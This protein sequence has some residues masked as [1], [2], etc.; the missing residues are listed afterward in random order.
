MHMLKSMLI[1]IYPIDK[2]KY[3]FSKA[4]QCLGLGKIYP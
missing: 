2:Y 1:L 3:K 4:Y